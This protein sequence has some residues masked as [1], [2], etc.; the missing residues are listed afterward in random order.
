MNIALPI[1]MASLPLEF[2]FAEPESTSGGGH[3]GRDSTVA[4]TVGDQRILRSS[5]RGEGA[6]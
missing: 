1:N 3:E 5:Q 2:L 4:A 6:E